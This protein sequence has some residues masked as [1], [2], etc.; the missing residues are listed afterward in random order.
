MEIYSKKR[1]MPPNQKVLEILQSA[2]E[3]ERESEV[4]IHKLIKLAK[5]PSDKE[6]LRLLYMDEHKHVKFF[7]EIYKKLSGRAAPQ[8]AR[9]TQRPLCWDLHSECEKMIHR[10]TENVEFYR[11]I[12]FGFTDNDIRDILFE[13]ITDEMNMAVKMT[14]MCSKNREFF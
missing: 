5:D 4:C 1:L 9:V 10:Y 14:H 12:Y 3:G 2:W 13:I 7:A 8:D 6:T 11:K